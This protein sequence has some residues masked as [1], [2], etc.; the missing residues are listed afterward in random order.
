MLLNSKSQILGVCGK[1]GHLVDVL[2]DSSKSLRFSVVALCPT[3]S[4]DSHRRHYLDMLN[5]SSPLFHQKRPS[6]PT[7]LDCALFPGCN[8][9]LFSD[10]LENALLAAA[11][12]DRYA[13]LC[14]GLVF[15]QQRP[16]VS[17]LHP[18][19]RNSQF[20]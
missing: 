18:H 2:T 13:L 5:L 12:L 8:S 16:S 15:Q 19:N 3:T 11:P 20:Q 7:S 9:T 4:L 1:I 6:V 17:T 10:C 14:H